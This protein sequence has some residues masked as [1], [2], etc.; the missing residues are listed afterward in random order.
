MSV[1]FSEAA[2]NDGLNDANNATA[3]VTCGVDIDVPLRLW[4]GGLLNIGVVLMMIDPGAA[5]STLVAP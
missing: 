3:P 4:Y 5:R 2:D 1:A